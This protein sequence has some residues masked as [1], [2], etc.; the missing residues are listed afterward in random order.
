MKLCPICQLNWIENEQNSCIVCDKINTN[1]KHN[2]S[3]GGGGKNPTA[4]FQEEFTVTMQKISW[5]KKQNILQMV[6]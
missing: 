3:I 2:G 4:H 6:H 1:N 5:K